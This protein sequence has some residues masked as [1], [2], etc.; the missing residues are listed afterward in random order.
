MSDPMRKY[1][2][3]EIAEWVPVR[4]DAAE[5]KAKEAI[6]DFDGWLENAGFCVMQVAEMQKAI[7]MKIRESVLESQR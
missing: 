2:C 1:R 3:G 5:R 6:L 4:G 7:A